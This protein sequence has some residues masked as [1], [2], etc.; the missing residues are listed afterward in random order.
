MRD[1]QEEEKA[2]ADDSIIS[3]VSSQQVGTGISFYIAPEKYLRQ[4]ILRIRSN[5]QRRL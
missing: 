1:E 4:V 3:I 5:L 2:G